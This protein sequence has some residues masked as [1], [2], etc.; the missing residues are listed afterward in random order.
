AA[1]I[2][3]PAALGGD[4]AHVLAL[5]L[6]TFAGATGNRHLDLVRRAQSAIAFLHLD[7]HG[8]A[9]LYAVAAPGTANAGFDGAQGLGIGVSR[10]EAGVDELL[11]D[12]WQLVD[13]GTE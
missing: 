10:L 6:G 4:D 2:E 12:Q 8:D 5:G 11:P 13:T 9:V 3:V 7:G 1:H